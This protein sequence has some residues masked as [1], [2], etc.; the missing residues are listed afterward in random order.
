MMM[1][2]FSYVAA[3]LLFAGLAT[4]PAKAG[5]RDDVQA[6]MDKAVAHYQSVGRAQSAKDF[7]N[8][9]GG[10]RHGEFY[11]VIQGTTGD[12]LAH[13]INAKLNGRNLLKIKDTDGHAFVQEMCD[14]ARDK[15][16]GWLSY[17]WVHPQTKKIAPK[18]AMVKRVEDG[19]F[20]TIGYY[21]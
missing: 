14:I 5:K 19:V 1:K 8:P 21:N 2:L 7:A 20:L 11:V 17:K 18:T 3:A 9:D 13:P 16:E 4:A 15:G 10:Y 6:L 12:V